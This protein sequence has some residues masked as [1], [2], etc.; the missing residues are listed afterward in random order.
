L[1]ASVKV[2]DKGAHTKVSFFF[3]GHDPVELAKPGNINHFK[4]A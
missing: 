4:N 3:T 1:A 2:H